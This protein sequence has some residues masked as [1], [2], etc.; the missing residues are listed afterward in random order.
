MTLIKILGITATIAAF[1]M[2]NVYANEAGNEAG[3]HKSDH[4]LK[5]DVNQD[6]KVSYEE[7]RTVGEK[8]MERH[9]KHMDANSDGF[10]DQSEKQAIRD[11]W[12]EKRKI[13]GERCQKPDSAKT[14]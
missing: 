14:Y 2:A 6:G 5:S 13:K 7:F 8:R 3:S 12:S 1:G 9:F 11:R 10:I 4:H